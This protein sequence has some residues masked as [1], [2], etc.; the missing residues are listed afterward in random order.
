VSA[1]LRSTG[2]IRA[3]PNPIRVDPRIPQAV[4][5]G[6]THLEWAAEGA[7]MVE[8]HV[9]C[10]AGPLVSRSGPS[11]SFDTG[12]WVRNGTTF[13]LQDVS[14]GHPLA[15]DY[16]LDT[17]TVAVRG[18]E[19][20]AVGAVE[21]GQLRRVT[22]ISREWGFDR[23]QPIDRYYVEEFVAAHAADIQGRVLE[24]GDDAYTR[25]FG[26][27]RVTIR[28]VMNYPHRTE[29]TTFLA[30]LA[31]AQAIPNDLFDCV[32]CTQT[33]QCVLDTRAAIDTLRRILKPGG[34]LLAT[35]P[36][37]SQTYD[38]VWGDRWYWNF[39]SISARALFGKAFGA[40][41]TRVEFRGNVLSAISFLHG[42]AS[43]ELTKEELDARDSAYEVTI[44]VRAV[45]TG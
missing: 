11:G 19:A 43:A 4:L 23:G 42:L 12:E 9:D 45:K 20:P 37:I 29:Q 3:E 30:D 39:T 33:L 28:D 24:F 17:V 32:I 27:D 18:V 34:V 13:F 26:G 31:N 6:A 36:G 5:L 1:P 16:T 15:P 7:S 10:P 44:A 25:R 22:P 41:A 21:F 35:F 8:V 38:A 40:A 2:R 14:G